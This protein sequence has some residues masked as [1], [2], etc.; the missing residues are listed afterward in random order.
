MRIHI[1]GAS[2][3]GTSTLGAALATALGYTLFDADNY[4]WLPTTPPFAHKRAP[5]ER[6]RQLV[7]DLSAHPNAVLAGSILDWGAALEDSFDLIVFL[8]LDTA[9]RIARLRTRETARLG[10]ADPAFLTWAAQY[11]EGPPSGRSLAKHRAWLLAR[12]CPIVEIHGDSS[13]P[14]R[15]Q[16]VLAALDRICDRRT[17]HAT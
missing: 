13:V 9:T 16:S 7:D 1:T 4:Y 11:D 2:G 5:A 6:L 3:S 17:P 8:Y 15:L 12:R 10:H 14:E